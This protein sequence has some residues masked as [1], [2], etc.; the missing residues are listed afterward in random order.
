MAKQLTKDNNAQ[1][2]LKFELGN[3]FC[4]RPSGFE[5]YKIACP[6]RTPSLPDSGRF[7]ETLTGNLSPGVSISPQPYARNLKFQ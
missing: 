2:M 1:F 4:L 7:V 5:T 3:D 6:S